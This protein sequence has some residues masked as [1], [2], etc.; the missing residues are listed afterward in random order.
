MDNQ[1]LMK[2]LRYDF[3][4]MSDDFLGILLS[5]VQNILPFL[6]GSNPWLILRKLEVSMFRTLQYFE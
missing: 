4:P 3:Q 1:T 6:I 2:T 5:L